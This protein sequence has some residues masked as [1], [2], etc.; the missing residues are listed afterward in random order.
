MRNGPYFCRTYILSSI[1]KANST[2]IHFTIINFGR[3]FP[4]I[5]LFSRLAWL[6]GTLTL[7]FSFLGGLGC[8]VLG[9][10]YVFLHPLFL[11]FGWSLNHSLSSWGV[12]FVLC[13]AI[14]RLGCGITNICDIRTFIQKCRGGGALLFIP[15]VFESTVGYIWVH[16]IIPLKASPCCAGSM[17]RSLCLFGAGTSVGSD[18]GAILLLVPLLR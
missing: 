5:Y 1:A 3:V 2:R 16:R 11:C 13:I 10:L 14:G 15:Q 8:H 12:P 6:Y 4:S 7:L 17:G 18:E 9:S